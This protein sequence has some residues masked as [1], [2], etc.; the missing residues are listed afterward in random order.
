[1]HAGRA[2]AGGGGGVFV[3]SFTFPTS[4]RLSYGHESGARHEACAHQNAEACVLACW[5]AVGCAFA[6]GWKVC[7]GLNEGGSHQQSS[8]PS[9]P[10]I[11]NK[12]RYA[13]SAAR[14][15]F[16]ALPLVGTSSRMC[17]SRRQEYSSWLSFVGKAGHELF[18]SVDL[19][20]YVSVG[21]V[22][23][24]TR[25]ICSSDKF[26][27]IKY[28]N[29]GIYSLLLLRVWSSQVEGF[30]SWVCLWCLVHFSE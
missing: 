23:V 28:Q 21:W 29:I 9:F 27:N 12:L 24:A 4:A 3:R 26:A 19:C 6:F 30:W 25:R 5:H 15:L 2:A 1:M 8:L 18:K 17:K 13:V 20:L 22:E 16:V 7:C 11:D 14:S 10:T